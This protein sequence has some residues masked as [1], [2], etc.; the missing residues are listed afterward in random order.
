VGRRTL[1]DWLRDLKQAKREERN[2]TILDL[3]L[4]CY[5]QEE[6]A[7]KLKIALGTGNNV[8]QNFRN[9]S[10]GRTETPD[11]LQLTNVWNFPKC[12][13]RYGYHHTK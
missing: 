8:L 12:D 6:I 5:T 3:Y 11:S 9:A 7:E 1:D 13:S 2:Q 4:A 10:L